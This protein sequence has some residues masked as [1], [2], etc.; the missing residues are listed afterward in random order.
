MTFYQT[1]EPKSFRVVG[2]GELSQL[3][4]HFD[5]KKLFFEGY[6]STTRYCLSK[7]TNLVNVS[8]D[9]KLF[10][11]S[12]QLL[13]KT[14][15]QYFNIPKNVVAINGNPFDEGSPVKRITVDPENKFF[16]DVDGVVYSRDMTILYVYPGNHGESLF[17]VPNTVKIIEVGAFSLSTM[18]KYVI[19]PKSVRYIK[20]YQF[21]RMDSIEFI[22]IQNSKNNIFLNEYKLLYQTNK[23][24]SI[25]HYVPIMTPSCKNFLF[26][27]SFHFILYITLFIIS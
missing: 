16:M 22:E 9:D 23:N 27:M 26:S 15:V 25:I 21:I 13:S 3:S 14:Q 10:N 1:S 12:D 11:I 6:S 19:I 17:V 24:A 8:F 2:T 20:E 7:Y 18:L 4:E 5:A